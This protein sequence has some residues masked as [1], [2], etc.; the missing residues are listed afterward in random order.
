VIVFKHDAGWNLTRND[1]FEDRH[2]QSL[3]REFV[4]LIRPKIKKRVLHGVLEVSKHRTTH[5]FL[6]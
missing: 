6:N 1:F 4:C 3:A 5:D 2:G